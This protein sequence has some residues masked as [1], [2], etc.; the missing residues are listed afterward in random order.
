[1]R[2]DQRLD[3]AVLQR[4]Q[5][6]V[7]EN[8]RTKSLFERTG[9]IGAEC[10]AGQSAYLGMRDRFEYFSIAAGLVDRGSVNFVNEDQRHVLKPLGSADNRLHGT[11]RNLLVDVL[12]DGS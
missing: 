3:I 9:P 6:R 12:A 7:L 1:M 4:I 2:R 10:R 8:D 5:K 11:N